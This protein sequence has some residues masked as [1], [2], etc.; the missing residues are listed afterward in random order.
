M[1]L[2]TVD[3]FLMFNGYWLD[4]T[5]DERVEFAL[6]VAAS[7]PDMPVQEVAR[8]LRS[9]IIYMDKYAQ[10]ATVILHEAVGRT[11]LIAGLERMEQRRQEGT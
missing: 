10:S 9:H 6:R 3:V 2:A 8:W 4:A 5:Q 11:A 1:A 7:E